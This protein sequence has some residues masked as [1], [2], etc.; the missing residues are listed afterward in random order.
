MM[1][2]SKVAMVAGWL[3]F[4]FSVGIGLGWLV[5]VFLKGLSD[6]KSQKGD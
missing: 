2:L 1:L 6:S 5:K 3:I 4:L